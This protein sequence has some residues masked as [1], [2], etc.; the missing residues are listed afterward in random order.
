MRPFSSVF[1]GSYFSSMK[2]RRSKTLP[3][4]PVILA[5]MSLPQMIKTTAPATIN[6]SKA[7]SIR[8]MILR[9]LD[10]GFF[11]FFIFLASFLVRVLPSVGVLLAVSCPLCSSKSKA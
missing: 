3:W 4:P 8:V 1:K 11:S 9:F 7:M 6:N 2:V 10:L 5:M